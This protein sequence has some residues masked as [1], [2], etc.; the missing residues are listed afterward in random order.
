MKINLDTLRKIRQQKAFSQ[1]YVAYILEISQAQYS[2]LEN[3]SMVFRIDTLG[4]LL[5]I[6]EVN[7]LEI[8]TFDNNQ[9]ELIT[10]S[11][12]IDNNKQRSLTKEELKKIEGG[13][14]M[15]SFH[16]LWEFTFITNFSMF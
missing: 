3:G 4:K 15:L 7:P 10:E 8:I 5:K 2:R 12:K 16:S 9:I 11:L 13:S 1:E 6:L 14:R